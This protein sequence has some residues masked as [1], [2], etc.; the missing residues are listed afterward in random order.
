MIDG[1]CLHA[2]AHALL[3]LLLGLWFSFRQLMPGTGD[4]VFVVVAPG[5]KPASMTT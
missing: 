3:D 2:H 4:C 1:F 5:V